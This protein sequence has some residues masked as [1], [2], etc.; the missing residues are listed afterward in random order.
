MEHARL[1]GWM[2]AADVFFLFLMLVL[3]KATGGRFIL[4]RLVAALNGEVHGVVLFVCESNRNGRG[5]GTFNP[6]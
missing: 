2:A 5:R 4:E 6:F 3:F 1:Q